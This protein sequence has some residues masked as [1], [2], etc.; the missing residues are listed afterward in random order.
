MIVEV[1]FL[2]GRTSVWGWLQWPRGGLG[3]EKLSLRH[4]VK[5]PATAGC[6]VEERSSAVGA[7][8]KISLKCTDILRFH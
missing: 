3:F 7:L 5:I 8:G 6:S 4:G 1:V 2:E